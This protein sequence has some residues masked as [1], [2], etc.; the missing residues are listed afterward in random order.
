MIRVAMAKQATASR[1]RFDKHSVASRIWRTIGDAMLHHVYIETRPQRSQ[2]SE[3]FRRSCEFHDLFD[4]EIR[5]FGVPL[6]KH[7][8]SDPNLIRH[9]DGWLGGTLLSDCCRHRDL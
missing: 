8:S 2:E 4:L 7:E 6:M 3:F 5:T 1:R 9:F